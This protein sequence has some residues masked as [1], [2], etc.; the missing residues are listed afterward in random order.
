MLAGYQKQKWSA[1]EASE[2]LH[3][4]LQDRWKG[5]SWVPDGKQAEQLSLSQE[6]FSAACNVS[7]RNEVTSHER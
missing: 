2:L 1:D 4:Y 6:L 7:E 5:Q 3:T